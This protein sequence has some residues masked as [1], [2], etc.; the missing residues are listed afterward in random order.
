[1]CWKWKESRWGDAEFVTE[2]KK[3]WSQKEQNI[4]FFFSR[5][6]GGRFLQSA[7]FQKCFGMR[8]RNFL[9]L[10]FLLVGRFKLKREVFK[11]LVLSK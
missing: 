3:D 5:K 4:F 1:M 11:I 7:F 2:A 9:F 8:V 10:N 6:R